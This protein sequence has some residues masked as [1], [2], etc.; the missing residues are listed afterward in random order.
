MAHYTTRT[1]SHPAHTSACCSIVLGP[2]QRQRREKY[3]R[4]TQPS[5]RPPPALQKRENEPCQYYTS[6]NQM[7]PICR[8]KMLSV[9]LHHPKIPFAGT[10]PLCPP[11]A[12]TV[13]NTPSSQ[14]RPAIKCIAAPVILLRLCCWWWCPMPSSPLPRTV[15]SEPCDGEGVARRR[16]LSLTSSSIDT[17]ETLMPSWL[18]VWRVVAASFP[19]KG[20]RMAGILD[21]VKPKSE[22][23]WV[24]VR[25]DSGGYNSICFLTIHRVLEKNLK[26][27]NPTSS[28]F[29]W[30]V[31]QQQAM[32]I[33]ELAWRLSVAIQHQ[34]GIVWLCSPTAYKLPRERDNVVPPISLFDQHLQFKHSVTGL[35]YHFKVD[36]GHI[37]VWSQSGDGDLQ[38]LK[39]SLPLLP[40]LHQHVTAG[41]PN[42]YSL[43]DKKAWRNTQAPFF[44][45]E[46]IPP[47]LHILSSTGTSPHNVPGDFPMSIF[48]HCN[49]I[50]ELI[51]ICFLGLSHVT[52]GQ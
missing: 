2:D 14:H 34:G 29:K 12:S 42:T 3:T 10:P 31:Y 16:S 37:S 8:Q 52:L 39:L 50:P 23:C 25:C 51:T 45:N 1:I 30:T 4:H 33:L 19:M 49:P 48:L 35:I 46:Q 13:N 27:H 20:G 36:Q 44:V 32:V 15:R 7:S 5:H 24:W 28:I 47:S 21:R 38:I 17:G 18:S 26:N 6:M 22:G 41:N 11:N 9:R 43:Y 40:H